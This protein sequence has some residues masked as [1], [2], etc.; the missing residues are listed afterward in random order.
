MWNIVTPHLLHLA[1]GH[2]V[3]RTSKLKQNHHENFRER[4]SAS[5]WCRGNLA[6]E[7]RLRE[8]NSV[9]PHVVDD[10]DVVHSL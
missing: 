4:V 10:G 5:G 3:V 7:F 6:V 8:V 9:C 2:W 1:D